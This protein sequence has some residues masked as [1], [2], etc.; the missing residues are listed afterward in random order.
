[1]ST[2]AR[3]VQRARDMHT[4]VERRVHVLIAEDDSE[5][6]ALLETALHEAAIHVEIARDG[7]EL[8]ER[9]VELGGATYACP[10]GAAWRR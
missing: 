9:L 4:G 3:G 5:L 2:P 1:M 8:R 10:G 7:H 6:R